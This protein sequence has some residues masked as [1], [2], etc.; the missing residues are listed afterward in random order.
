M[1][2][3]SIGE[4]WRHHRAHARIGALSTTAFEREP[5]P[6]AIS[7]AP[8]AEATP[9]T[10]NFTVNVTSGPLSGTVE[11]GNFSYD[12]SSI[13]PNGYNNATGLLT[14][15]NFT[16]NGTTYNSTTANTGWL[17]FDSAGDLNSFLFGNNCAA[18]GCTV[19][20]GF[21]NF[22]A[23]VGSGGFVYSL[24]GVN[25]AFFGN[26]TLDHVGV[27]EPG[28]LGLFC[29]GLLLLLFGAASRQRWAVK[30]FE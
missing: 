4:A 10:A 27:P 22:F 21:D 2:S 19:I 29:F 23:D 6:V 16:F 24:P 7:F 25:N 14:A 12:S 20:F 17:G 26:V 8:V 28:A 15:L 3:V 11:N 18:G 30:R 13:V 9:I 5:S 1:K